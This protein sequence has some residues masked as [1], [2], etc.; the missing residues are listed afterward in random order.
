MA[1]VLTNYQGNLMLGLIGNNSTTFYVA[2]FT[3][4]PTDLGSFANEV[5]G[6]SYARQPTKFTVASGKT[7]GNVSPLSFTN[8][9]TTGTVHYVGIC[10]TLT[11][12]T[13]DLLVYAQLNGSTGVAWTTGQTFKM[14][15]ND[16]VINL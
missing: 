16:I 12:T 8:M 6:G 13:N 4:S 2:L 9:P 10:R 7:T 1:S 5:A 14:E 11:G 3:A 15:I